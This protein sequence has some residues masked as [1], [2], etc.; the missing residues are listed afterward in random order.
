MSNP[1][2]PLGTGA[3][4]RRSHEMSASMGGREGL[5]GRGGR[6][7]PLPTVSTSHCTCVVIGR[8][9]DGRQVGLDTDRRRP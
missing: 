3:R 6:G 2:A 4:W 9:G 5:A 1:D 8:W 7:L